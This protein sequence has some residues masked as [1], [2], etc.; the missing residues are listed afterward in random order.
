ME[1]SIN[2]G[3]HFAHRFFSLTNDFV[4]LPF[5]GFVHLHSFTRNHALNATSHFCCCCC[6]CYY[7]YYYYYYYYCFR[8]LLSERSARH[9]IT[10]EFENA[11]RDNTKIELSRFYCQNITIVCYNFDFHF[12]THNLFKFILLKH[13]TFI[14]CKSRVKPR[15]FNHFNFA[16]VAKNLAI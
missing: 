1:I 12:S 7:Y 2:C 16:T 14:C 15:Q 3:W 13:N 8:L 9:D 4:H 11:K 6:C 5:R 10:A